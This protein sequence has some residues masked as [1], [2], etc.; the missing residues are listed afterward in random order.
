MLDV[1]DRS[2]PSRDMSR[3]CALS[4]YVDRVASS[5]TRVQRSMSA[6]PLSSPALDDDDDTLSKP[7]R[8]CPL[9]LLPLR[10]END[11]SPPVDFRRRIVGLSVA[12]AD[13]TSLLGREH[14]H[15]GCVQREANARR[16]SARAA[17]VFAS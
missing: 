9:A 1:R 13:I 10:R 11:S 2:M 12:A 3:S 16:F 7:D 5:A 15:A 6:A 14:E 17:F 4:T 8:R